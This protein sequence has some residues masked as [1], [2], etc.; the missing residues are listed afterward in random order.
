MIYRVWWGEVRFVDLATGDHRMSTGP[1]PAGRK[2]LGM[3]HSTSGRRGGRRRGGPGW[4]PGPRGPGRQRGRGRCFRRISPL[5]HLLLLSSLYDQHTLGPPTPS[6]LERAPPNL[7]TNPPASLEFL[8]E[9]KPKLGAVGP[10][11]PAQH[12]NGGF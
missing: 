2:Q 11:S 8:R 10:R 1:N 3:E 4:R 5:T 7:S 12:N 6:L 9:Q